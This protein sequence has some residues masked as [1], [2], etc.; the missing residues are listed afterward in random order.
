[1]GSDG[2]MITCVCM[3]PCLDTSASLPSFSFTAANRIHVKRT[4]YGGKGVN[5]AV[6]LSH[7]GARAALVYLSPTEDAAGLK[8]F[9]EAQGVDPIA[10]PCPGRLR[11]NLK[12]HI[13]D[14][15]QTLEINGDITVPADCLE[16]AKTAV[17]GL[18]GDWL[19]LNGSLPSGADA[20]FYRD[21]IRLAKGR[22]VALDCDGEPLKKALSAS[23]YL[24]K[25]NLEEFKALTGVLP[26]DVREAARISH[27]LIGEYRLHLICLSLGADGCV[28]TAQ[29][30][31]W[32]SPALPVPV[33]G[34]HGAGDSMLAALCHRLSKGDALHDALRYATACACASIQKE[35][36]EL[37]TREETER[38]F[39][40]AKAEKIL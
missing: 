25:P 3:N 1:M 33:R 16:S 2:R 12:I 10:V 4:D 28:L 37:A 20:C 19:L 9:L 14:M 8:A 38:L 23:P 6:V 31:S 36:T 27:E 29:D 17:Q 35:G 26:K 32:F 40:D 22:K 11:T 5:T 13:E 15:A 24:I 30:E 18:P 39:P 21:L 7:L 34:E